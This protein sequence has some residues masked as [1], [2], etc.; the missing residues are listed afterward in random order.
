MEPL[1]FS[2]IAGA[3]GALVP[4]TAAAWARQHGL[5]PVWQLGIAVADM[6]GAMRALEAEQCPAFLDLTGKPK[7]WVERGVAKKIRGNLALS[8]RQGL[9]IELLGPET[10]TRFYS[11]HFDSGGRPVLHHLGYLTHDLPGYRK[12]LEQLG[13]ALAVH[14]V[15]ALPAYKVEFMY[16]DTRT[17][18]G[19][20]TELIDYRI[21]GRPSKPLPG[22]VTSLGKAQRRLTRR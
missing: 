5:P 22:I 4:V 3:P 2:G 8:Y 17:E 9:E 20:Y 19:L 21:L 6:R 11:A 1:T 14:G 10:G 12:R 13:V 16:F 7:Q 15:I 18:L